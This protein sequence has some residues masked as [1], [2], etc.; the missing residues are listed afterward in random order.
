MQNGKFVIGWAYGK[1]ITPHCLTRQRLADPAGLQACRLNSCATA[2][3]SGFVI[4]SEQ[5]SLR[6]QLAKKNQALKPAS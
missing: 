2:A 3:T 1:Y 5:P 6:L 4:K